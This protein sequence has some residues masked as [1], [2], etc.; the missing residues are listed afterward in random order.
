MMDTHGL[1]GQ[2]LTDGCIAPQGMRQGALESCKNQQ[3]K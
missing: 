3:Y 1:V 2:L